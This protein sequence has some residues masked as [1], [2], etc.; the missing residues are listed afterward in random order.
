[1]ELQIFHGT[2]ML[3]KSTSGCPGRR[4]GRVSE[5]MRR[6]AAGD[7][8]EEVAMAWSRLGWSEL[9][10]W[11]SIVHIPIFNWEPRNYESTSQPYDTL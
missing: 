2:S 6:L 11:A 5:C 8:Q 9:D 3:V 4:H 7:G 10:M 1:M